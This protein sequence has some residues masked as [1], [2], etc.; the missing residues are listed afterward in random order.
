MAACAHGGAGAV[1]GRLLSQRALRGERETRP[2]D[3][4]VWGLQE[5]PGLSRSVSAA[6]Q[7]G[8]MKRLRTPKRLG[9]PLLTHLEKMMRNQN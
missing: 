1:E 9:C 8:Q 3:L 4:G 2:A 7:V 6:G 5:S